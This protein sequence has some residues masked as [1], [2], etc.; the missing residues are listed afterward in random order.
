MSTICDTSARNGRSAWAPRAQFRPN[1][2]ASAWRSEMQNASAVWPVSVRPLVSTM[3]PEIHTG[4]SGVPRRCSS[5]RTANTAAF[6]FSGSKMVSISSRSAPPS[7][8]ASAS[9]VY[10]STSSMKVMLRSPGSL[11]SGEMEHVR[12]VGASEPATKRGRSGLRRV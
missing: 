7:S 5:S 12:F 6:E 2:A 1:A 9:S 8:S 11:T 10:E 3:V 4:R